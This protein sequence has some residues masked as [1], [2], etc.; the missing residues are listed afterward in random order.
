MSERRQMAR[1]GDYSTLNRKIVA[2]ILCFSFVPL[3]IL[4]LSMYV[5]FSDSITARMTDSIRTLANN[6]RNAIDLFLEE[7]ISQLHTL[8]YTHSIDHLQNE[9]YLGSVLNLMQSRGRAFVD[10]GVIDQAG[11]H[12]AYT[13]PYSLHGLNYANESWFQET[14]ARGV[15][16][17][18]VF[19]GFRNEPHFVIAVMRREGDG[20][21]V[22]RAT[23]DAYV[24]DGLVKTP[25][26]GTGGDSFVLSRKGVLQTHPRFGASILDRVE[27][28]D[29]SDFSGVRIEKIN[30]H[31]E[32]ALV[33]STWLKGKDWALVIRE[34]PREEPAELLNARRLVLGLGAGGLL[35]ITAGAV[36][37][38]RHM[39]QQLAEADQ[40]KEELNESLIHSAR[41]AT[42]GV[43]SANIAH[44]VNNPLAI[45]KEQVGWVRDLLE[46]EDASTCKNMD[47]LLESAQSIES[48]A[49][50]AKRI[51]E[52]L[53]NFSR[54]SQPIR[55]NVDVNRLV[56]Q[57]I[58]FVKKEA[59][60]RKI[61][62]QTELS[63]DVPETLIDS[64]Q[65]QQV[66]LNILNNAVDAIGREGVI[67][68]KTSFNALEREISVSVADTGPGIPNEMIDKIFQPFFTTKESGE[69]TGLG[70]SIS[71]TIVQRLGGRI[72]VASEIG[73]G[74]TFTVYVP[75]ANELH[76]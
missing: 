59:R 68:T 66:F 10:L 50:R 71:S 6:K 17:S 74:T 3:F 61:T 8:A 25:V 65:L 28:F 19:S 12:V 20:F 13:G 60:K 69:G 44:E 75:V 52:R 70:L 14:V 9:E 72:M 43:L 39:I 55:E 11:N 38:T 67:K 76:H 73:K 15:C 21:W 18:D 22:L 56:E 37:I 41:L 32:K 42:L 16:V 46:K 63:R 4:G 26:A 27:Y 29:L 49:D 57:T 31:G 36:L 40:E 24:F 51:T 33:A 53:L 34:D 45:I 2:T 62:I 47:E 23:I 5:L 1:V 54:R 64:T 7:R 30:I 48:S 58:E 35:L